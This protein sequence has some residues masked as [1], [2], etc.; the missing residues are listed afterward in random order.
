M[1]KILIFKECSNCGTPV[2]EH[3]VSVAPTS[4]SYIEK[5]YDDDGYGDDDSFI[6]YCVGTST[7][8]YC[9]SCGANGR[10]Y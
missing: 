1:S 7:T 2:V 9:I 4:Y 8:A 10:E 5:H 6:A 3:E